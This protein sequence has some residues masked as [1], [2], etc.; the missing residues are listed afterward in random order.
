MSKKDDFTASSQRLDELHRKLNSADFFDAKLYRRNHGIYAL[1]S[2]INHIIGCVLSDN[3]EPVPILVSR[4]YDYLQDIP[5]R[6][7][8]VNYYAL[9]KEYLDVIQTIIDA[10]T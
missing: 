10:K 9:V 7:E 4:G 6:P 3:F 5:V 8:A 1:S 2:T